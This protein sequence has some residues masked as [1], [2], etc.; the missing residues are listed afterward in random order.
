MNNQIKLN[1]NPLVTY[2]EKL[3]KDFTK[4]DILRY[5]EENKIKMINFRYVGGDGRLKV[6]NF[7]INNYA[8]LEQILTAGERVDGSSL[9]SFIEAGSSDLYVVPRF[10]TAYLDP[11]AEI[12]TLGFLCSYFNKDGEPLENAP[13]YV[14]RKAHR[15]F[16]EV[17]G[18]MEFYAMGEM[19]YYVI[20]E[21]EDAFPAVDQKGYHEAA[22]FSK[23]EEFRC[24]AMQYISQVGGQ[25]KYGHSEVGNFVQENKI[26]EQNEIEFLPTLVT[27]AVD[28]LI[29]GKWIINKLAYEYG[30]DVTFAPKITVGKA[31]S[32]F[33]IHTCIMKNGKNQYVENGKLS[34][35][36]KKAIAG[37]MTCASSLTAFGNTN[38]T[39]YFRLVPQ[40]EAP[41]TVC[42]GDRNRSA[43]VRV[44]LGWNSVTDMCALAN[45]NEKTE[46]RDFSGKQTIEYRAPDG[47]ANLYYLLAG[48]VTAARHGFEMENAIEFA[49]KKYVDVDIHKNGNE[50]K[51]NGFEHLPTSCYESADLLEKNKEIYTKYGVFSEATINEIIK[52]LRNY[53][54]KNIREEIASQPEILQKLVDKYFYC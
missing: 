9:F 42:W 7:V 14:L 17:T 23:F 32:G 52:N 15:V 37:F 36:A 20:G 13:G 24:K 6:L 46:K 45:L 27:D 50:T 12:P 39:S 8:Y 48:L 1:P 19:E 34:D 29:L 40:Q 22:P 30:L 25:I 18:G 47:S 4:T 41:T 44:P 3:P 38:P 54:D 10:N 53:K 11:F 31:G 5:I 26:Y 33:H 16:K 21:K 35:T 2:L 43:L 28:Q 49:D 51:T